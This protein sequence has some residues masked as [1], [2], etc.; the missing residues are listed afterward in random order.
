MLLVPLA[1]PVFCTKIASRFVRTFTGMDNHSLRVL[2][3]ELLDVDISKDQQMSD[4]GQ[5]VLSQEQLDYAANDVLY[6]HR[7][8]SVLV[9]RLIRE[10]RMGLAEACFEFL[11]TRARL[12]VEGWSDPDIFDRR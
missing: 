3:K 11:P 1:A 10:D 7:L 5:E 4:W 12:D 2:C 6:L 8:Q 9:K